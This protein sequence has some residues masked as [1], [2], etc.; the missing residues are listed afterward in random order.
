MQAPHQPFCF[1]TQFHTLGCQSPQ[2]FISFAFLSI[3]Q[4]SYPPHTV[5]APARI[6]L[7]WTPPAFPSPSPQ[8]S[9]TVHWS[10]WFW[11]IWGSAYSGSTEFDQTGSASMPR[12]SSAPG[13][14]HILYGSSGRTGNESIFPCNQW[15]ICRSRSPSLSCNSQVCCSSLFQAT[16]SVKPGPGRLTD[17]RCWSC[18]TGLPESWWTL[19][20]FCR[21]CLS[22]CILFEA[23]ESC[24]RLCNSKPGFT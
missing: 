6:L 23:G 18:V 11:G 15:G 20:S 1:R 21:P 7:S 10:S 2:T 24:V 8:I 12:M 22:Y 19:L 13:I 3:E 14:P 17:T 16:F 9:W 4:P 5:S